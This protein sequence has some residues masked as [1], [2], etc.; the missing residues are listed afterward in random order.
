MSSS[1]NF[2]PGDLVV[3]IDAS[4]SNHPGPLELG[5]V[6]KVDSV[7]D[8]RIKIGK[9]A[10]FSTRFSFAKTYYVKQFLNQIL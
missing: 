1:N 9:F 5:S 8:D 7:G 4:F 3:C 10:Y 2:K 6:H